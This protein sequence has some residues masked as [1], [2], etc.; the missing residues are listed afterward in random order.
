MQGLYSLEVKTT[1]QD[2][3]FSNHSS[4][5][6]VEKNRINFFPKT[7]QKIFLTVSS[8]RLNRDMHMSGSKNPAMLKQSVT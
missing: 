1:N 7:K 8:F 2:V 3:S 6:T 4:K 5:R